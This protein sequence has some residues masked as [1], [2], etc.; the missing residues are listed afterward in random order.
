[1]SLSRPALSSRAEGFVWQHHVIMRLNRMVAVPGF[2]VL[3]L[4]PSSVRAQDPTED[5]IVGKSTK[6]EVRARFGAPAYETERYWSYYAHEMGPPPYPAWLREVRH[7]QRMVVFEFDD[8]GVL[9]RRSYAGWP[10]P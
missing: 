1:M 3:V 6:A 2:L 10:S 5:F 8:R 7:L 9:L 4:A